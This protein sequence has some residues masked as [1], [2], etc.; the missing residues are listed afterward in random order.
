MNNKTTAP[1]NGDILLKEEIYK[2]TQERKSET[3]FKNSTELKKMPEI[4]VR[5]RDE[6]YW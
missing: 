6:K 4:S 5:N 2:I 3:S 1:V